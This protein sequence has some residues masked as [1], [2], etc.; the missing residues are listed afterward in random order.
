MDYML[1]MSVLQGGAHRAKQLE[2]VGDVEPVPTSAPDPAWPAMPNGAAAAI[3]RVNAVEWPS[4]AN[5]GRGG[6]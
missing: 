6:T 5:H 4:A 3:R 1:L 2:A